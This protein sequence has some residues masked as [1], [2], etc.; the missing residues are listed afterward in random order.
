MF[1][2][3]ESYL[4]TPFSEATTVISSSPSNDVRKSSTAV[5]LKRTFSLIVGDRG[6]GSVRLVD[7]DPEPP[8]KSANESTSGPREHSFE[9]Y[10]VDFIEHGSFAN[11]V[12][13]ANNPFPTRGQEKGRD[14]HLDEPADFANNL[15]SSKTQA[16]EPGW[17]NLQLDTEQFLPKFVPLWSQ[18]EPV[19][20]LSSKKVSLVTAIKAR[21]RKSKEG[22]IIRL[23]RQSEHGSEEVADIHMSRRKGYNRYRIMSW[24][25][26]ASPKLL[27]S[28][29]D[30]WTTEAD[31]NQIH[32][33]ADTSKPQELSTT[34][35]RYIPVLENLRLQSASEP[36]NFNFKP[37]GSSI[38]PSESVSVVNFGPSASSALLEDASSAARVTVLP[39]ELAISPLSREYSFAQSENSA[40]IRRPSPVPTASAPASPVVEVSNHRDNEQLEEEVSVRSLQR[41]SS[42]SF[43]LAQAFET[44]MLQETPEASLNW[45]LR[46]KG[47]DREND[48]FIIPP[49]ENDPTRNILGW[50]IKSHT[51]NEKS[52]REGERPL[53]E[54]LDLEVVTPIDQ[55]AGQSRFDERLDLEVVSPID[56]SAGQSCFGEGSSPICSPATLQDLR[57]IGRER[58]AGDASYMDN[59]CLRET[60]GLARRSRS[61]IFNPAQLQASHTRSS[62]DSQDAVLHRPLSPMLPSTKPTYCTRHPLGE[63]SLNQTSQSSEFITGDELPDSRGLDSEMLPSNTSHTVL[64]PLGGASSQVSSPP[65]LSDT[66]KIEGDL[67][68]TVANEATARETEDLA[69]NSQYWTYHESLLG[70]DDKLAHTHFSGTRIPQAVNPILSFANSVV[71]SG[72]QAILDYL[73][74]ALDT[75]TRGTKIPNDMI[76][77]RWTCVR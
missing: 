65:L 11:A 67:D 51:S 47:L 12:S 48:K 69:E 39:L 9:D 20:S 56:R 42:F 58:F 36:T 30:T 40:L 4:E 57:T 54:S 41:N 70:L 55:S 50:L 13:A 1:S 32:E 43:P 5:L 73:T 66:A 31:G 28:P 33:M 26:G 35:L 45:P 2:P 72:L 75:S 22:L 7:K 52:T 63:S 19:S 27:L 10:D 16:A 61:S 53:N 44:R 6:E 8:E 68:T 62:H 3:R 23:L 38:G 17:A 25:R 18:K 60:E 21:I 46:S 37:S 77:V 24:V 34:G 71:A 59:G 29:R 76:R 14:V 15:P 74:I 64:L 49:D